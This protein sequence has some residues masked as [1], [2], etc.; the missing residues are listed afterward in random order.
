MTGESKI[1]IIV[2]DDP[3]MS[4]AMVRLLATSG[5]AV[6]SY[7][8]AEELLAAE[9]AGNAALLILDIQLPGMSGPEL[10]QHLADEGICPPVIFITGYDR[11]S[12]RAKAEEAGAAYL[13]KPFHGHQLI[14]TIRLRLPARRDESSG[15]DPNYPES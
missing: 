13:A 1:L 14:E 2:D 12:F 3:S 9:R 10:Q 5:W 15:F 7:I 8:S 11:P 6:L 4:E